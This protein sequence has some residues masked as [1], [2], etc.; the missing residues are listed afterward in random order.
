[1]VF[2]KHNSELNLRTILERSVEMYSIWVR[3]ST[4]V[5]IFFAAVI[6]SFRKLISSTKLLHYILSLLSLFLVTILIDVILDYTMQLRRS[7]RHVFRN[8][9]PICK[10][11]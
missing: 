2:K 8:N 6:L 7:N 9:P 3:S 10:L 5:F 1:M 11:Y 4:Y